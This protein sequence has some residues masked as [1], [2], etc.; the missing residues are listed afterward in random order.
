MIATPPVLFVFSVPFCPCV[1]HASVSVRLRAARVL[2]KVYLRFA[3]RAHTNACVAAV[4][5]VNGVPAVHNSSRRS[6]LHAL[7]FRSCYSRL[8]PLSKFACSEL[9]SYNPQ[10]Y[11]QVRPFMTPPPDFVPRPCSRNREQPQAFEIP[12]LSLLLYCTIQL[13]VT[14]TPNPPPPSGKSISCMLLFV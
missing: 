2:V 11:S 3:Q 5:F 12:I 10:C 7:P 14:N 1:C 13:F 4:H 9:L 6:H 8:S